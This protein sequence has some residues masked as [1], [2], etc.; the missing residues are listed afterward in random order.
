MKFNLST[1]AAKGTKNYMGATA[2]RL[3]PE[4]ELYTAVATCVVDDSYYEK[5][6]ERLD[7]IRQLIAQCSPAFVAKLA[8]YA[9]KEMN[10]RSIP[11]V[12]AVELAK[13]T[14]GNNLVSKTVN[15]IVQRADE[16]K[17][18]LAYYQ[19]ANK[20]TEAKKLNKL[21]KQVQKGLAIAFNKFDEYQFAKY[22]T[23]AEVKMKDALFLVH[24]E[25]KDEAQQVLFNKIAKDELATPYT[26]ET[27]LSELGKKTF[28]SEAE[29]QHAIAMQWEELVMS[30]KLGYMALLRNLRNILTK[31]SAKA[32]TEA[33]A[34]LTDA[35]KVKKAKQLPFRYLSAF[36]EIEK[37]TSEIAFEDRSERIALAIAALEK[38][39]LIACD[40]ISVNE[41]KT[42]ILSDNS[43]SM[44]GDAAGKSLV[45]AMSNR[46]TADIAN[47][48]AVLYW[49]K[50]DNTS[51]G[52]FGDH[53]I[54]P[55]LNR[56][57]SLF[58]NFKL[59]NSE[60]KKCG[61]STERGIF[62]Y[63]DKLISTKTIADRIIIFSD[64]QVGAG[65]NWYDHRGNRGDN[66]NKLLKQYLVINPAV[67]V[68]S[69][70]LKGYGNS[71]TKTE[72][73]NTVLV[74]GWSEKIFDMIHYIENGSTV[75]DQ[76][77]HVEL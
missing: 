30:G 24:P 1:N 35:N 60:A 74:S 51:I 15:G 29:K 7:R 27:A 11:V 25:A 4:M 63:M 75:V 49:N 42:V 8:I 46:K 66:F 55:M 62:E 65:C 47:L 9:R 38:A 23:A 77:N 48:F 31:G 44:Y 5:Q 14:S 19:I 59:I 17:E 64:C 33:L 58:E 16:I 53:L 73:K 54:Q 68:Y 32:F 26:W 36:T 70:D 56:K 6:E 61:P 37:V 43:G 13:A 20:R 10:L 39:L 3:T 50:S 2:Y 12:L 52:L 21:S 69:V 45:S 34:I 67:K 40:N 57:S 22:N 71:L 28:A 72:N 18:I 76:I 41:G